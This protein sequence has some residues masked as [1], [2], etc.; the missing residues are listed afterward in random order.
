MD[1]EQH[2]HDTQ[3]RQVVD[4]HAG[5]EAHGMPGGR[6]AGHEQRPSHDDHTAHEQHAAHDKHAGH[7]VAMFRDRFWIS[8]LL[9]VPVLSGRRPFRTGSTSRCRRSRSRIDPRH[10]RNRGLPLWRTPVPEGRLREIRD[11]RPGMMLLI[12]LAILVA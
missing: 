10:L 8:L 4:E 11:R 5:H 7:S 12:S 9:T 3:K 2:Q 6:H 1:H